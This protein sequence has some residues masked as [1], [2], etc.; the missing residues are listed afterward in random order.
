MSARGSRARARDEALSRQLAALDPLDQCSLLI[1]RGL[2]AGAEKPPAGASEERIPGCETNIWISLA[3]TAEG[4]VLRARSDSVLVDGALSLVAEVCALA[5]PS[6]LEEFAPLIIDAIDDSVIDRD[7]KR[8]G[9]E[10]VLARIRDAARS[11]NSGC[12]PRSPIER[13]ERS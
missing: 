4:V 12:D 8:N 9:I 5:R 6:E 13:K 7:I 2:G 1:E 11:G 10:K 3:R